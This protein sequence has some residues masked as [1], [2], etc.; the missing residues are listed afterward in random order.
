MDYDPKNKTRF[1]HLTNNALVD[2]F[3]NSPK[4]TKADKS[5]SQSPT[6]LR[7]RSQSKDK[8]DNNVSESDEEGGDGSGSDEDPDNIWSS[9]EFAEHL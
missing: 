5:N 3:K 6:K 4:K 1:A 9:D 7:N 2:K 8:S